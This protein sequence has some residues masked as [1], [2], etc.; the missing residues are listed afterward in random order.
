MFCFFS[1]V[2]FAAD[3]SNAPFIGEKSNSTIQEYINEVKAENFT[4]AL[5]SNDGPASLDMRGEEKQGNNVAGRKSPIK[6][7]LYSAVIPGAG[8]L[9]TGSK[10]KALAFFGLE[11][12]SWTGHIIYNKKGDDNTDTYETY[13]NTYWSE[14]RYENWLEMHWGVR[15]DDSVFNNLGYSLFTHHLPSTNVQ[16]YYEMIGKYNQFVYGWD[17]TDYTTSDDNPHPTAAS[18]RRLKYE[19]LRND[20]NRMYDRASTALIVTLVNHVISG[21]EAA[22]AA[23]SHNKNAGALAQKVSFK[24]YTAKTGDE[25]FP[26]LS[27]TYKF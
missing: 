26:M 12:L 27:M 1:V 9:Y 21:T 5:A 25:Y 22:L 15:D 24:A 14:N 17:D 20:A 11:V 4:S 19:G 10:T 2:V 3:K 23:R 13:A 8:Q 6:A 7:F 18:P 16:Q